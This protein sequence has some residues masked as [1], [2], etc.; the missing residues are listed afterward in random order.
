MK[1]AICKHGT[2]RPG[3]TLV[4]FERDNAVVVIR[5][6]P[7]L[8]CTVCGEEYL[9]RD[10]MRTLSETADRAQHEG[11]ELSVQHFRAA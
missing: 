1:C 10:V 6:V 2:L 8:L 7:A 4:S 9:E 11:H 5:G 3:Q